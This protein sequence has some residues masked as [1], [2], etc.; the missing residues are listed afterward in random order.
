MRQ[1]LV[2]T[3]QSPI[4][5]MKGFPIDA[6]V[7]IRPITTPTKHFIA[8]YDLSLLS[9]ILKKKFTMLYI[10]LRYFLKVFKFSYSIAINILFAHHTL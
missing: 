5:N 6:P 8:V 2:K 10:F 4:A 9:V 7:S 3:K 1:K